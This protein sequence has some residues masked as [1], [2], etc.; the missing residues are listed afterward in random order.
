[1]AGEQKTALMTNSDKRKQHKTRPSA[2]CHYTR[3]MSNGPRQYRDQNVRC[4]TFSS[5]R[6]D[7]CHVISG[8]VI[9]NDIQASNVATKLE[10]SRI[11]L[12]WLHVYIYF[13]CFNDMSFSFILCEAAE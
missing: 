12:V 1:M 7:P 5:Y 2:L 3:T 8:T 9:D 13:P 10:L 4:S 6:I 11:K